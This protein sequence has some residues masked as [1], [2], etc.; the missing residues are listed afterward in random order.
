MFNHLF[1]QT[2]EKILLQMNTEGSNASMGPEGCR[3]ASL[4]A[5]IKKIKL[6]PNVSKRFCQQATCHTSPL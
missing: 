3:K 1:A 2:I 4:S 6:M 5:I